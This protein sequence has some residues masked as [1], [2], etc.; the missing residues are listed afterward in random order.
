VTIAVG[1]KVR[2]GIVLAA[3]SATTLIGPSGVSN[4]YN[5]ANKIVNLRKGLPIGFMTWGVGGFAEA[6]IATLAKDFRQS[7]SDHFPT[8]AYTVE[9]VAA[10][11]RGFL[12]PM[13]VPTLQ[14]IEPAARGFG[15]LV[16]GHSEDQQLGQCWVVECDVATGQLSP[17][18][19]VLS[20]NVGIGWWGQPKWLQRLILGVDFEALAATL[21]EDLHFP[22]EQLGPA[23]EIY[24]QRGLADFVHPAMPIQDA[25]NLGRFFVDTTK[26]ATE[27]C[28]GH[29]V[30]GGPTEV[31]AITK[32]EGFKWVHRKH[33][34]DREFNPPLGGNDD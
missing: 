30:V 14:E 21:V 17:P 31:A 26:A 32:H 11:V 12:E 5:H 7:W 34:F 13:A 19:Q 20:G 8:E 10:S 1:I 4:I 24:K 25:V 2:D 28:S 6:S 27:F 16:A 3:D 9:E 29:L 22:Q 18:V 23:F 33:Y 15:F